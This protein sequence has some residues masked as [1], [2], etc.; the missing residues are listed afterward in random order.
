MSEPEYLQLFTYDFF[1][2][3]SCVYCSII[4]AGIQGKI[5]NTL[6]IIRIECLFMFTKLIT[7]NPCIIII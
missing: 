3:C 7:N 2:S 1:I 4:V 6:L 5:N